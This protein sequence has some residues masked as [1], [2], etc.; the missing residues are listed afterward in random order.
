MGLV[1]GKLWLLLMLTALN[2]TSAA[3]P[4]ECQLEQ[5]NAYFEALDKV[6]QEGSTVAD[7]DHLLA[8]LHE[9]VRYVHVDYGADFE[10]DAWRA[11]FIGNLERGA[12]ANGPEQKMGILT[13]IHG[14]NHAAVEYA[15]G[16]VSPDGVWEG[17]EP[18]LVLF[19][20]TDGKISRIEELW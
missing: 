3:C 10:R 14:K 16:A 8:Q 19:A 9:D 6:Y 11:A 17:E 7:V 13:V 5:V 4:A 12:Y 2:G 20:F 1:Q 15:H 18:L